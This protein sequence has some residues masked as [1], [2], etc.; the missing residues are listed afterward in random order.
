MFGPVKLFF[1]FER[2]QWS[3]EDNEW[4]LPVI[5]Q[6]DFKVGKVDNKAHQH[7]GNNSNSGGGSG[8]G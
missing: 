5:K 7:H 4:L 6:R 2:A 1:Y 8:Y 3:E